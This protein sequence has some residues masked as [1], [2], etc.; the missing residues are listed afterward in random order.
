LNTKIAKTR[1]FKIAAWLINFFIGSDD[2]SLYLVDL[3]LE[4]ER[5]FEETYKIRFLNAAQ[6]LSTE[7]IRMALIIAQL[8]K[9][10]AIDFID[11]IK[12]IKFDMKL[13]KPKEIEGKLEN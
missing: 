13:F 8:F 3:L 2:N 11:Y 7:I 10:Y 12:T 5:E 6:D 4:G 9:R 1:T